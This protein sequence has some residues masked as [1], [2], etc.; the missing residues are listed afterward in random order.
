MNNDC[1]RTIV[2]PLT[3]LSF[4]G[5]FRNFMGNVVQQPRQWVGGVFVSIKFLARIISGRIIGHPD[6]YLLTMDFELIRNRPRR[7]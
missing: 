2:H 4:H 5:Q 6:I 3:G 1:A 7:N